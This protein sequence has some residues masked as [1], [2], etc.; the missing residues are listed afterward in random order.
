[1][2]EPTEPLSTWKHCCY[3]LELLPLSQERYGVMCRKC[4]ADRFIHQRNALSAVRTAIK[5][6]KIRP[7]HR[8]YCVDCG[9]PAKL[10]DHRDYS[11]PLEIE[12]V[13]RP[14]NTLRGPAEYR[15]KKDKEIYEI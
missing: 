14:C 6:G 7:A 4:L 13:C 12:P 3:C 9:Q 11:K 10:Y 2:P 1:M 5:Q 15:P 8:F